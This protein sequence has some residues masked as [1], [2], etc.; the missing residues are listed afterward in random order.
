MATKLTH[1]LWIAATVALTCHPGASQASFV[2]CSSV[3][4]SCTLPDYYVGI[5]NGTYGDPQSFDGSFDINP[6]ND[7]IADLNVT[8]G[9]PL[10]TTFNSANSP[11]ISQTPG[12]GSPYTYD[13]EDS[14]GTYELELVL[15]NWGDLL[16]GHDGAVIDPSSQVIDLKTG[17]SVVA[18]N[19][20]GNLEVPAPA[21]LPVFVSALGMLGVF[22]RRRKRTAA[23]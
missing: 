1:A 17:N 8:F 10:S 9:S 7:S 4:A 21:A 18:N 20:Q 22:R 6:N 11:S 16:A 14:T 23:A 15:D 19:I 3:S 2:L 13:I 12:T 5:D